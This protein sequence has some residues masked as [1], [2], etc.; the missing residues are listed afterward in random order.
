MT[1]ELNCSRCGYIHISDNNI[2]FPKSCPIC[3]SSRIK[4][5]IKRNPLDYHYQLTIDE[6]YH[7]LK[8]IPKLPILTQEI[9]RKKLIKSGGVH[10]L[11]I[12]QSKNHLK[13]IL[14]KKEAI[15]YISLINNQNFGLAIISNSIVIVSPD[16]PIRLH[17]GLNHS[18]LKSIEEIFDSDI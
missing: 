7:F 10:I 11:C 2:S 1:T 14:T 15:Y 3:R 6:I 17:V 13:K 9:I 12:D 4:K 18:L 5:I 8:E 16:S